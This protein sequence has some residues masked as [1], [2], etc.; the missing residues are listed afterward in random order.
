MKQTHC[1]ICGKKLSFLFTSWQKY[2]GH[3]ICTK[4]DIKRG[5]AESKRI[6]AESKEKRQQLYREF[7]DDIEKKKQEFLA[8]KNGPKTIS[9]TRATCQSCGNIWHYG[10]NEQFENFTNSLNNA[11]NAMMCCGGCL[12]A[13]FMSSKPVVDL[14]KCPKCGSKAVKTQQVTHEV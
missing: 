13:L 4:C 8:R 14:N 10:K 1:H 6:G 5:W 9:E 2:Q 7:N 11:G 3:K 12:P